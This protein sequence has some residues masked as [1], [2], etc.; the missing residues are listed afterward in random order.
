MKTILSLTIALVLFVAQNATSQDY[1]FRVL[2]NKGSNQVQTAGTFEPT[3]LKTGA[4]LNSGDQIITASGSY[5]GLVHRTGKTMEIRTP[6]TYSIS[7]LQG[8]VNKGTSSVANRYMNFVMNKMN[9]GDG[10]VYTNYRKNSNVTGAVSR[11]TNSD[12]INMRPLQN[13]VVSGINY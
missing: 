1:I 13:P 6:G 5:I 10:N 11:A 4:K 9:E 3:S 8:R 12:A 2:A 7:E